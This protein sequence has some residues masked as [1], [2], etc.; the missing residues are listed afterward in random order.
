MS[1]T[2]GPSLKIVS[3]TTKLIVSLRDILS[4]KSSLTVFQNFLLSDIELMLMLA[5]YFFLILVYDKLILFDEFSM[6]F[7]SP[8]AVKIYTVISWFIICNF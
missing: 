6:N 8:I 1:G 7:I 3:F 4:E 2:T 5:K